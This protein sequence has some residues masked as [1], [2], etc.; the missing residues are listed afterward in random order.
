MMV[1]P[2]RAGSLAC[3]ASIAS[4]RALLLSALSLAACSADAVPE[5]EPTFATRGAYFALVV[6]GEYQLLRTLLV[7]SRGSPDETLFVVPYIV[8]PASFDEA[9][10]LAKDP[11]LPTGQVTA[12]GSRYVVQREWRAVWFRSVS[13]EEEEAFR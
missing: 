6:D 1:R 8:T 3:G 10:E 12:I 5:P 4:R 2:W 11:T 13:P 9:R 7:L